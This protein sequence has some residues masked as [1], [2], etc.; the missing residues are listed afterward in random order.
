MAE[1]RIAA[2]KRETAE[3]QISAEWNLDGTG[4]AEIDTGV[5]FFDHMLTLF[6]VHGLFDL[7]IE[8]EG[9]IDVDYHHLVEDLGIVLGDCFHEAVG[10]KAGIRRYG[11]FYLPMDE[12]LVRVAV[13][14]SNR[15][16]LDYDLPASPGFVK[17]F[18]VGLFREF[19]QGFVNQSRINL[20]IRR[21]A[22]IEPHH[23]AEAA[24]KG[25]ARALDEA[26]Q[27]DPRRGGKVASTKGTLNG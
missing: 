22:G 15:P 12:S 8:A 14:V 20:H 6:T 23:L 9:D 21:E 5:P 17:D 24:F 7:K 2:R 25:T 4:Q 10:D 3:T 27:I 18:N 16:W 13:D 19:F 11:F 26:T 1:Q